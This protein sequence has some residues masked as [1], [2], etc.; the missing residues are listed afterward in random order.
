[1]R[2]V[3]KKIFIQSAETFKIMYG[4]DLRIPNL[5]YLT[6]GEVKVW[7]YQK[8]VF[9]IFI[10]RKFFKEKKTIVNCELR[11]NFFNILR[12]LM[13]LWNTWHHKIKLIQDYLRQ[14]LAL[15]CFILILKEEN[16]MFENKIYSQEIRLVTKNELDLIFNNI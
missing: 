9:K 7:F 6:K 2:N 8:K 1:M 13:K 11:K 14:I 3:Q 16:K 4:V 12:F 5:L 10:G 15:L